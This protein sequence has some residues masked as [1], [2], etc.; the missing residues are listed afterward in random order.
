MTLILIFVHKELAGKFMVYQYLVRR[1]KVPGNLGFYFGVLCDVWKDLP[2][3]LGE[4]GRAVCG[5]RC[6]RLTCVAMCF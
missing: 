5:V 3:E 4:G 6:G 1:W 2:L